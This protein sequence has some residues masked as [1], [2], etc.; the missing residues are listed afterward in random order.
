MQPAEALV[1]VVEDGPADASE[2]A[3]STS[4][5]KGGGGPRARLEADVV[6]NPE[7]PKVEQQGGEA[8]SPDVKHSRRLERG[9]VDEGDKQKRPPS[10]KQAP[11]KEDHARPEPEPL[12]TARAMPQP[13]STYLTNLALIRPT[14]R[15][16]VPAITDYGLIHHCKFFPRFTTD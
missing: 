2:S 4:P 10:V 11:A 3:R 12:K 7:S 16:F 15:V 5:N 14:N 9:D 8:A 6:A 1:K 13:L